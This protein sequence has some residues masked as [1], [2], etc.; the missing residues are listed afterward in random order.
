[1]KSQSFLSQTIIKFE[2]NNYTNDIARLMKLYISPIDRNMN[3]N[4]SLTGFILFSRRKSDL[5]EAGL[6]EHFHQDN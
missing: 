4:C 2:S 1:M 6:P 5:Q 3:K